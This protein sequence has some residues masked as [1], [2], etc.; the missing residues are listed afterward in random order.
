MWI[1]MKNTYSGP[2]GLFLKGVKYDL[3]KATIKHLPKSSY[4]KCKAPWEEHKKETEP[5]NCRQPKLNI[6]TEPLP[7]PMEELGEAE[8][9]KEAETDGPK[10]AK[11]QGPKRTPPKK[12]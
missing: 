3:P 2:W 11:G 5:E 6:P 12:H 7:P 4:A 10:K 9:P 1:L 8:F